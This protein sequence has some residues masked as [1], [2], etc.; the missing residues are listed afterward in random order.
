MAKN[1]TLVIL[2]YIPPVER[3]ETASKKAQTV[4]AIPIRTQMKRKLL[5]YMLEWCE[6]EKHEIRIMLSKTGINAM[7]SVSGVCMVDSHPLIAFPAFV[8]FVVSTYCLY[9]KFKENI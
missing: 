1:D 3:A 2:S 8:W 7:A 4:T 5:K 6:L 9:K